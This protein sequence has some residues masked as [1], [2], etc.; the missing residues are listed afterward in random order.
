MDSKSVMHEPKGDGCGLNFCTAFVLVSFFAR[1]QPE[2][3]RVLV[4]ANRLMLIAGKPPPTN[5]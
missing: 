2:T 3:D 5:E 4:K 1:P